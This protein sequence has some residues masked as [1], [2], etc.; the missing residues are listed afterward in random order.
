MLDDLGLVTAIQWLT[1]NSLQKAG[2]TFNFKTRGRVKRLDSQL[3]ITLFRVIQEATHNIAK[4]SDA[5][6]ANIS[7]YFLKSAIKVTVTDD[8]RGFDVEEAMSTKDR[9]RGLG[10]LGM[11][12]RVQ[13]MK[14]TIEIRS[15]LRGGTEIDI[16]IP[17]VKES[18]NG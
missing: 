1:E 16:E 17:L 13:L 7:L 4:H 12:E 5:K 18:Q 10:I 14:G 3:A 15:R 9:P 11:K 2:I 6:S 8:G